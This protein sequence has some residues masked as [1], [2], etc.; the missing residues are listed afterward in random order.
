MICRKNAEGDDP[1]LAQPCINAFRQNICM[2]G[3]AMIELREAP[4]MGI[5]VFAK[6][7]IPSGQ[8]LGEYLGELVPPENDP[9]DGLYIFSLTNDVIVDAGQYGNWTVR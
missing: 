1:C 4:G 9:R 5:G 7:P 2:P 3:E 6:F 8:I